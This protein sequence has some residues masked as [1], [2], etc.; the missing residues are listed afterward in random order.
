MIG[1]GGGGDALLPRHTHTHTHTHTHKHNRKTANTRIS[2]LHV[3]S[4]G[5]DKDPAAALLYT[6]RA[7]AYISLRQQSQALRDLNK[8]V[9]LDEGFVQ[10]S[11]GVGNSWEC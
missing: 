5:A 9:E 7:A 8:A 3:R 10:V 1:A 6:K 11:M 2:P 4:C